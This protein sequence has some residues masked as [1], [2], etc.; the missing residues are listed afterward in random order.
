MVTAS[1]L[2]FIGATSFDKKFHAYNKLSGKL[3]WEADLPPHGMLRHPFIESTGASTSSS[4]VE[5][6]RT[7]RPRAAA[8]SASRCRGDHSIDYERP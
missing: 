1:G 5:V 4:Y 8:S 6:E 3:L 2:V 7:R